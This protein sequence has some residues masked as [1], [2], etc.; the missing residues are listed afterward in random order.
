[1]QDIGLASPAEWA[2]R[3]VGNR[4]M[5]AEDVVRRRDRQNARRLRGRASTKRAEAHQE[6]QPDDGD[7][8]SCGQARQPAA[9]LAPGTGLCAA[10]P[11]AAAYSAELP[12][13]A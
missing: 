13:V 9:R 3:C 10:A 2:Q 8:Q 1:M 7:P 4:P 11:A 6:E 5:G 12:A